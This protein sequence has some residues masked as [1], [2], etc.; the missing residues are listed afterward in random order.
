MLQERWIAMLKSDFTIEVVDNVICLVDLNQG[1]T[2]IT[3]N[4]SGVVN[5]L[6]DAGYNLA[7]W[8]VIYRDTLGIW[9][10]LRVDVQGHFIGFRGLGG[11]RD[12]DSAIAYVKHLC[13]SLLNQEGRG[14]QI[15]HKTAGEKR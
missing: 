4:A 12:R 8:P 14:T 5:T 13:A 15:Q 7:E 10:W 3:S 2:T 1:G 9:G 6:Q 11:Q